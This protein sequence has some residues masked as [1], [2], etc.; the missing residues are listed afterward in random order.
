MFV[1]LIA[2][3]ENYLVP[4]KRYC[5]KNEQSDVSKASSNSFLV[6]RILY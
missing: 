3:V 4:A 6:N 2:F 1:Y 5:L